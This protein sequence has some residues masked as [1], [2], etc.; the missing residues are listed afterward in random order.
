MSGLEI[1]GVVASTLQIAEIGMRLSVRLCSFYRQIKD[2]DRSAERLANDVSL[3]CSILHQ[4]GKILEQDIETKICSQQAFLT[5]REVLNEC[6]K[7]F[8]QIEDAVEKKDPGSGK[9]R[10]ERGTRRLTIVV[11]GPD[12]DVLRS[13]LDRLKSTMLLMLNVII[14]ARDIKRSSHD[15][16]LGSQ[17]QL[18]EALLR[19]KADFDAGRNHQNETVNI[20]TNKNRQIKSPQ[21]TMMT[22]PNQ[23]TCRGPFPD[24]EI[25]KYHNLVRSLLQEID[26][27][28]AAFPRDRH[29]RIR[30]G[31]I[32]VHEAEL[33]MFRES[34]GEEAIRTFDSPI[35]EKIQPFNLNKGG[36]G[37]SAFEPPQ[38]KYLPKSRS[39]FTP[40]DDS[41]SVL[42]RHFS[43]TPW[44]KSAQDGQKTETFQNNLPD[45]IPESRNGTRIFPYRPRLKLS[46]DIPSEDSATAQSSPVNSSVSQNEDVGKDIPSMKIVLPP[47][48]PQAEE[49]PSTGV[50]DSSNS[51]SPGVRRASTGSLGS[52]T[53]NRRVMSG[54]DTEDPANKMKRTPSRDLHVPS[55][56]PDGFG[57]S[58]ADS[59]GVEVAPP[60]APAS[61]TIWDWEDAL[62]GSPTPLLPSPEFFWPWPPF[63]LPSE[64]DATGSQDEGISNSSYM[65]HQ[66]ESQAHAFY[67]D[68][69]SVGVLAPDLKDLLV[70]WTTIAPED[71]HL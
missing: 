28:Q 24:N 7:I 11:L 59:A 50:Q 47:P 37:P 61:M 8:K 43:N 67:G 16:S 3:T 5:A 64:G 71:I 23:T 49:S 21:L 51:F 41:G 34:H 38:K 25:D 63:V 56:R 57:D 68:S 33:A 1:I 20:N 30:D 62:D 46:I 40:I 26:A 70:A 19:E 17:R 60:P 12:L 52:R 10:W 22:Q 36:H 66:L 18:I 44:A 29:V 4:L 39:I 6:E 53:G 42:A 14:Y 69:V 15:S 48:S 13:H 45:D 31:V 32:T 65:A 54:Y 27:Y 35:F 58:S 2:A 9:T 55:M